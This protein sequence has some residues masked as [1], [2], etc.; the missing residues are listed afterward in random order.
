M[1]PILT[2]FGPFFLYSYT[3][4][5]GLGIAAGIALTAFLEIRDTQRRPGWL[6]GLLAA[7][8]IA[9]IGGRILFVG[10]NWT[11]YQENLDEI[12]LV[13]RGGL[14]Y[15]GVL[16]AG[17]GALW[18]W[19]RRKGTKFGPYAGLIA[20]AIILMSVFAWFACWLEGCAYGQETVFGPLAADLP[21]SFG[22]FGL[23]YQTQWMGL[24]LSVV[25]LGFILIIG[26][27]IR[28]LLIFWVSLLALSIGRLIVGFYRGDEAPKFGVFR[29]DS[30]A[31]FVIVIL[32][33]VIIIILVGRQRYIRNDHQDKTELD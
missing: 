33:I 17:L 25:A 27:R 29:L 23:R 26:R 15:H 19:A 13:W 12:G 4:V 20:P 32:C 7:S 30:L 21:D 31:D 18:L 10:L 8:L 5:L 3:V 14:S 2:R 24:I 11:Y 6:D 1:H 16:I 22:V 9:I 28:P